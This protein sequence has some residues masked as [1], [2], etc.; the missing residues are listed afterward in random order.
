[1]AFGFGRA[2]ALEITPGISRLVKKVVLL[3]I[4]ITRYSQVILPKN[5]RCSVVWR[6]YEVYPLITKECICHIRTII[7]MGIT[8][9][10]LQNSYTILVIVVCI[11]Q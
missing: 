6:E 7:Y 5:H 9:L 2:H 10:L 1:M 3:H 11:R 4:E 8:L